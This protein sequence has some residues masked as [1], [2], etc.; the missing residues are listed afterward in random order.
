M[1]DLLLINGNS[2][3]VPLADKSV[4][5]I[6]FSPPYWNLRDYGTASWEGGDPDCD[7]LGPPKVTQAGFNERYFGRPPSES[8]KQSEL[9]VPYQDVCKKCG[10]VR[11]D[12]QLGLERLHDC[13]GW[14]T[15]SPCGECYVCH[16]V[17]VCREMWR[18]LRDDGTMWI[19]LGDN[20]ARS[21][22]WSN[23][24]GLDGMKRGE[25]G[26]AAS[27]RQGGRNGQKT[28]AGLKE[29]DLVGVPWRV[30]LALQADGWYLRSDIIWS[31]PNAMPDST[32]DRPTKSHEY[33]FLFSKNKRY[34]YD[35]HAIKEPLADSSFSRMSQIDGEKDL[36]GRNRRTVWTI[37]E[38]EFEQ[39]LT[40]KAAQSVSPDTW[41]IPTQTYAGAHFATWPEALVE[42]CIRASASERGV[43]PTCGA[44]WKRVVKKGT[45]HPT[46][47]CYGSPI[48][49]QGPCEA[50][51]GTGREMV[52]KTETQR[53]IEAANT[54]RTDGKVAGPG[55]Q[56]YKVET[57]EV[58]DK[59]NGTGVTDV[60]TW[61]EDVAT[62]ATVPA[63][64][65]DPFAGSGTTLVVARREGRNAIGIDLSLKYLRENAHERLGITHLDAYKNWESIPRTSRKNVSQAAPLLDMLTRIAD[66]ATQ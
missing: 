31:K 16:I 9:L 35:H 36:S 59:C 58:C 17:Q 62:W 14:A 55:G 61:P 45:W 12:K 25:S 40:W 56:N 18:V 49:T 43:C 1:S 19:N 13:L 34:F 41:H 28:P 53:S 29:K 5:A 3:H 6:M 52:Y 20:F 33:I 54:G 60:E 30:A 44:Q 37:P 39:F 22:G 4:H 8:D 46:C 24:S 26:R 48:I 32:E 7:H 11:V 50:C 47:R 10:A 2:T 65:L 66:N 63:T 42:P 21:G 57:G 27:N 64:I 51:E 38:D 23:N 15:G